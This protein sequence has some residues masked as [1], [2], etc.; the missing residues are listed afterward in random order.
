MAK[1]PTYVDLLAALGTLLAEYASIDELLDNVVAQSPEG[2]T[3]E[4]QRKQRVSNSARDR[5]QKIWQNALPG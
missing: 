2:L 5:I 3:P 4:E 1:K